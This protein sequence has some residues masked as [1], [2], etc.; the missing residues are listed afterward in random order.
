M[1]VFQQDLYTSRCKNLV[2]E[3]EWAG[4]KVLRFKA[5]ILLRK[6]IVFIPIG[7]KY[8]VA[9]GKE[10]ERQRERQRERER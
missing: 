8:Q 4:K 6:K 9:C 2:G 3:K 5:A 7:K 1:G 10:R